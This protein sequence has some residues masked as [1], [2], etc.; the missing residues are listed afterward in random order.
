[1][2]MIFEKSLVA[3][4]DIPSGSELS[5][6]LVNILKP[7]TGISAARLEEFIGKVLRRDVVEGQLFVEE[8]FL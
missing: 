3:A 7:G 1:M 5:R 6:D 8:D 4:K 2:K